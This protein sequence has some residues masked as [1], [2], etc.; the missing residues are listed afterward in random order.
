MA[1]EGGG[2]PIARSR[3]GL[4]VPQR[5]CFLVTVTVF[6]GVCTALRFADFPKKRFRN[7][8]CVFAPRNVLSP[9]PKRVFASRNVLSQTQTPLFG[10]AI[11]LSCLTLS[12]NHSRPCPTSFPHDAYG[13]VERIMIDKSLSNMNKTFNRTINYL[14]LFSE[15]NF[16]ESQSDSFEPSLPGP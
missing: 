1:L 6:P 9:T 2:L 4:N 11:L 5:V 15:M 7:L 14:G 3:Y 13:T 10:T 16:L 12:V 8:R